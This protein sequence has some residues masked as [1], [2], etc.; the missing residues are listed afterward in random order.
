MRATSIVNLLDLPHLYGMTM[1]TRLNST[2]KLPLPY[3][4]KRERAC[5]KVKLLARLRNGNNMMNRGFTLIEI[6]ITVGI[7]AIMSIVLTQVF[8]S[9]LV[10]NTKNEVVR[11]VKQNGDFVLD[12]MVRLLQNSRKVVT[13]CDL[14]G[15]TSST[16]SILNPDGGTTTFEC[17]SDSGV[18]RIASTSAN[19]PAYLSTSNVTLT[20]ANCDAAISFTCSAAPDGTQSVKVS[21]TIAQKGSSP[22]SY[23]KDSSTFGT[24]ITLRN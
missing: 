14:T 17:R 16:L 21:F 10:T 20:G 12:N 3:H 18:L 7:V 2:W 22:K 19:V 6:V 11:E 23:E 5:I 13:T 24:T 15:T 1:L 4:G 9:T 8:I